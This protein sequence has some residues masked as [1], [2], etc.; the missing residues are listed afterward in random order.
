MV[1]DLTPATYRKIGSKSV[2]QL[3]DALDGCDV[4]M[5]LRIQRERIGASLV[6][7]L[8][9]VSRSLRS[10]G[11]PYGPNPN[12]VVLH[13]GPVNRG[14]EVDDEVADH[15][16]S[17]SRPGHEWRCSFGWQSFICLPLRK[18]RDLI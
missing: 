9:G 13:P 10:Q 7:S 14:V 5:T 6:P 18:A 3:D 17:D 1:P 16:R 12:M 2:H 8:R 4:V 15:E 11:D